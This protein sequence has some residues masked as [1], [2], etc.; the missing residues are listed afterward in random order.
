MPLPVGSMSP[1]TAL[2]AMAA[3]TALP[4]R[5]RISTPARA[6]SGWLAATMP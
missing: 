6:A 2:A 1:M 5:S 3:S 4:P